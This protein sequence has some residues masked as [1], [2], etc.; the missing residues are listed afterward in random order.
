MPTCTP[1]RPGN[2]KHRQEEALGPLT[3]IVNFAGVSTNAR[4]D[5][6]NAHDLAI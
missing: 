3:G 5:A 4:V 2:P 6:I 1:S